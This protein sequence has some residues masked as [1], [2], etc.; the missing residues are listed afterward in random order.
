[1]QELDVDCKEMGCEVNGDHKPCCFAGEIFC[2]SHNSALLAT[3]GDGNEDRG[4]PDKSSAQRE[5]L[6]VDGSK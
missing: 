2:R 3:F 5:H 6:Q 4:R 1:M